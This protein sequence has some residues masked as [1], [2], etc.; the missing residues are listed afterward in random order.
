MADKYEMII[1]N[2]SNIELRFAD[3]ET[4][5]QFL[6]L[7]KEQKAVIVNIEY[8]AAFDRIDKSEEG[9]EQ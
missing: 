5:E 1:L 9:E 4:C 8:T 6:E 7:A 3:F 2:L